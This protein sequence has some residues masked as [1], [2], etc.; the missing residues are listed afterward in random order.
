MDGETDLR[1]QD[2]VDNPQLFSPFDNVLV[3][4]TQIQIPDPIG[5]LIENRLILTSDVF[6]AY[7]ARCAFRGQL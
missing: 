2:S 3:R 4:D 6:L 7:V 1:P 5:Q